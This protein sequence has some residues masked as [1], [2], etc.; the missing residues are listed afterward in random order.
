MKEED[1]VGWSPSSPLFIV[2]IVI[3]SYCTI[4]KDVGE[5]IWSRKCK[6]SFSDL[7]LFPSYAAF[8]LVSLPLL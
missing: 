7:P 5:N 8:I 2:C 3:Q 6:K 4:P 1:K